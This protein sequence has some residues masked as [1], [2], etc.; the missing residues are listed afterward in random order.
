[1]SFKW[2]CKICQNLLTR[3]KRF[4]PHFKL[5]WFR[6]CQRFII[7]HSVDKSKIFLKVLY[8]TPNRW[9]RKINLVKT[10]K[11]QN[12]LKTRLKCSLN[13]RCCP[14]E[15]NKLSLLSSCLKRFRLS[16]ISAF[17]LV[18]YILKV[19]V[20]DIHKRA[21]C[22]FDDDTFWNLFKLKKIKWHSIE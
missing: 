1:M 6:L 14:F 3:Y 18:S 2:F 10:I 22:F 9:A 12:K 11:C 19:W 13:F 21:A 17:F 7:F 8:V 4:T 20:I 15:D 16:M 5:K